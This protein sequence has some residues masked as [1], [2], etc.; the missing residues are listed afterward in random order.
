M[1]EIPEI[2]VLDYV[3]FNVSALDNSYEALICSD[4]IIENLTCGPLDQLAVHLPEARA[5]PSHGSFKLQL[6]ESIKTSL[7]FNKFTVARFL[8][9]VN[10]PN[11]LKFANT[12]ENE[13]SQLEE[14]RKFHIALY[15]KDHLQHSAGRTDDIMCGVL[16]SSSTF[17]DFSCLND[18]GPTH[19]EII[20]EVFGTVFKYDA[21]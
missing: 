9:I 3:I 11:M 7:W 15:A 19:Q 21:Y 4:G 10:V 17:A 5:S 20:V 18:L 1:E 6:D 13:I 2:S 12:I 14:T 16:T 8:H